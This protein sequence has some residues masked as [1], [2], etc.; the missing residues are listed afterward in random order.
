M[1]FSIL[2]INTWRKNEVKS[3]RQ[4][5]A[6]VSK[7]QSDPDRE[8]RLKERFKGAITGESHTLQ[9][10]LDPVFKFRGQEM[11]PFH[12]NNAASRVVKAEAD[13]SS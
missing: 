1:C 8:S 7:I 5:Q 13:R 11:L 10:L 2:S 3:R 12:N 9:N 4:D 6:P